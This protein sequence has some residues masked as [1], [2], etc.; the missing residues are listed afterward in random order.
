ML[1]IKQEEHSIGLHRFFICFDGLGVGDEPGASQGATPGAKSGRG[2]QET[3]RS[4]EEPF[5]G[6][7]G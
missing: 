5:G 7:Q 4:L 2:V 6:G 1:L 3:G